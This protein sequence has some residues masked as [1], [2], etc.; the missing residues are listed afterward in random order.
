MW[1]VVWFAAF[2]HATAGSKEVAIEISSQQKSLVFLTC[3]SSWQ[4]RMHA[5][6]LY[7]SALTQAPHQQHMFL[8]PCSIDIQ[9]PQH[10][11][12]RSGAASLTF[13]LMACGF[14]TSCCTR[15]GFSRDSSA[16]PVPATQ[17]QVWHLPNE[18]S[19]LTSWI[20]AF[21][22]VLLFGAEGHY[23]CM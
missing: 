5:E 21:T 14:C 22:T 17:T 23:W 4:W 19:S 11:S 18:S 12:T 20:N 6:Y 13:L 7:P 1:F 8:L 15:D 9:L 2:S 16:L 3:A 10:S